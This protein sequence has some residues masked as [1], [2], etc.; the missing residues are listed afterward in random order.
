MTMHAA[1]GLEFPVVFLIAVEDGLLPHQRSMEDPAQIEEERRLMFVAITRAQ[2][3]LQLSRARKREFRGQRRTT[4]PSGFLMELPR[5]EMELVDS[6]PDF[7][8]WQEDS[9]E[10]DDDSAF[11]ED[12]PAEE[13]SV[14]VRGESRSPA[15]RH[16][17]AG[18]MTAAALGQDQATATPP[19][20]PEKFKHGMMVEHPE[21]GSGTIIALGGTA[22]LRSATVDFP[23]MGMEKKFMLKYSNLRPANEESA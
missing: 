6:A 7:P 3:Q 4:I 9:N 19:V 11:F 16:A 2:Q 15:T 10:W 20:S 5:D 12:S 21:Y 23:A 17:T 1:K 8:S 14:D 13:S 22:D 18:L